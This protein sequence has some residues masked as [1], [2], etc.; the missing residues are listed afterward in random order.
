M[1]KTDRVKFIYK[2]LELLK[3]CEIKS[4]KDEEFLLEAVQKKLGEEKCK[5]KIA[6]Y[7]TK[8]IVVQDYYK[9]YAPHLR[10]QRWRF[11]NMLARRFN[12]ESCLI[13]RLIVVAAAVVV[14]A[15]VVVAPRW[16]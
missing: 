14:A 16:S 10:F 3:D 5:A 6:A 11:D 4:K 13:Q 7:L 2:T 8:K 15:V 12:S 9:R 1:N